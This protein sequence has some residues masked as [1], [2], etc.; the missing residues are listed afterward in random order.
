M[1][2]ATSLLRLYIP[3]IIWV[4]SGWLLGR[5]LPHSIPQGLGKFLFWVGVPLSIFAFLRQADLSATVWLAP[6]TAWAA[7]LLGAL[8]A[9]CWIQGQLYFTRSCTPADRRSDHPLLQRPTQGSFLLSAMVGNTGYLGYPVSLALVGTQHFGWAVFY[10]TLGSTLGAYGLGVVL[11]AH[12]SESN[13]SGQLWQAI[14][15]NPAFWSFWIGLG[16]RP[17]HLP[18]VVETGLRSCAWMIIALSLLLLGMRLSRIASWQSLQYATVSLGIKMLIVPLL[19]GLEL[20]R[21]GI[22]GLPQLS[23]VL[24]MAMPPAFATLVIAEA[25]DLDRDLTVTTLALGSIA[26]LVLLPLWLWLFAP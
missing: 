26:L 23:I 16:L 22:T 10:D 15:K 4:G 12:F 17:V 11:A 18:D 25:Y 7:L 1:N 24:Q 3:L 20:P 21:L 6:C 19:L 9:W 8:L 2:E 14:V 5:W 13:H